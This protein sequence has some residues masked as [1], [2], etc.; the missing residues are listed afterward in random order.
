MAREVRVTTV[1]EWYALTFREKVALAIESK[2]WRT[3]QQI[4]ALLN[5]DVDRVKG[6][7]HNM[8]LFSKRKYRIDYMPGR[9]GRN[10]TS[11][12]A[13]VRIRKVNYLGNHR[14]VGRREESET[15]SADTMTL[16]NKLWR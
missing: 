13:K 5:T 14:W 8:R 1:D 12:P 11:I 2:G 16:I 10:M 7:V 9:G 15:K 4:A 3:Y 6:A